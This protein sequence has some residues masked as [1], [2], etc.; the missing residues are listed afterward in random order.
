MVGDDAE[1]IEDLIEKAAVLRRNTDAYLELR[2]VISEVENDRAQLDGLRPSA[3]NEDKPPHSESSLFVAVGDST[4]RQIVGRKLHGD[5]VTGK[6][7][8]AVATELAG[9]VGQHGAVDIQLDTEQTTR[10]LFN[11]GTCDFNAIF[12]AHWPL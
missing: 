6:N 5:A 7:A 8:D 4:L 2:G 1:R 10:K 9:Q 12:F 3:E 11:D